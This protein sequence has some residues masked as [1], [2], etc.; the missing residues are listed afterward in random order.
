MVQRLSSEKFRRTPRICQT[1]SRGYRRFRSAEGI[2]RRRPSFLAGSAEYCR[3]NGLYPAAQHA[4]HNLA[5]SNLFRRLL[6]VTYLPG[7]RI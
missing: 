6:A 3:T 4:T 2:R 1:I 5:T 7:L